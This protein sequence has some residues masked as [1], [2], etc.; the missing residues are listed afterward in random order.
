MTIKTKIMKTKLLYL[1][2]I[3][4]LSIQFVNAQCSRSGTFVQSDPAYFISGDANITFA[5]NGNKEVVF[6]SN[7]QTVQGADLRVYLSRTNDIAN[8]ASNAIQIS[9]QLINDDGGTSGPGVSPI[10]GLM[11]FSVPTDL[12]IDTYGFIVIQCIAINERWGYVS[13]GE[14]TGASCS[15]LSIEANNVLQTVSLY[16]NPATDKFEVINNKQLPLS[17]VL[18]DVIGNKVK[19]LANS[20]LKKQSFSL[21]GLNS[22]VYLVEINSGDQRIIKRLIKR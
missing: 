17:I 22:G 18:Y 13:L 16:P 2:L 10:T 20:Q 3:I 11:R 5:E 15:V 6:E 9:G 14:V 8:A 19:I 12:E 4:L 1:T 7:F 21:M